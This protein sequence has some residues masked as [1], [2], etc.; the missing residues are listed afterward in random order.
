MRVCEAIRL[1]LFIV[2]AAAWVGEQVQAT[3][4]QTRPSIAL[5]QPAKVSPRKESVPTKEAEISKYRYTAGVLTGGSDSTEFAIVQEMATQLASG[6]ETGPRGETAL[7]VMPMVGN[8]HAHRT[9]FSTGQSHPT[10][11]IS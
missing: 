5:S 1:G 10:A 6:Q 8:G 2:I 9:I 7:R 11:C 3:L 4:A